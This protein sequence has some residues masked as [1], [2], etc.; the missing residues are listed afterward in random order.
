MYIF[1]SWK[2]SKANWVKN[3]VSDKTNRLKFESKITPVFDRSGN[4]ILSGKEGL[5]NDS[6]QASSLPKEQI[7]VEAIVTINEGQQWG[8]IIGYAQDNGSY[9]RGWILGYNEDSFL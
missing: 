3:T 9:E 2:F 4:F 6:V 1:Y 5:F 8:S 7:S